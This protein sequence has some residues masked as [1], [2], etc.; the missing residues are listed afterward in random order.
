QRPQELRTQGG[1]RALRAARSGCAYR[2][3][4]SRWRARAGHALGNPGYPSAGGDGRGLALAGAEMK[5]ETQR[6]AGL[7]RQLLDG[8]SGLEGVSL[9]GSAEHRVPHNL[10]LAFDGVDGELLLL[11]LRDLAL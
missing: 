5:A 6:I 8:L 1:R 11:A 3:A 2:G 7:H 4:D 9:N 10:N